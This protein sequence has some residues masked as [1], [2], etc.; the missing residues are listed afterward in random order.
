MVA[1]HQILKLWMDRASQPPFTDNKTPNPLLPL[2]TSESVQA[3]RLAVVRFNPM[4]IGDSTEPA[5]IDELSV[6][7]AMAGRRGL[8]QLSPVASDSSST[9][10]PEDNGGTSW[11]TCIKR[12][13]SLGVR[14]RSKQMDLTDVELGLQVSPPL[15]V[16]V[17]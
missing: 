13:L 3:D 17:S 9:G 10:D 15:T 11:C 5:Q 6:P 12:R 7:T 2:H 14:R 8:Q 1:N 16:P 4:G